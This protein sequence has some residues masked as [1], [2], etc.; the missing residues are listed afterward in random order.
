MTLST[1]TR[2]RFLVRFLIIPLLWY[3]TGMGQ[4]H[5]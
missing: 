4:N 2:W 1:P 3:I 5:R